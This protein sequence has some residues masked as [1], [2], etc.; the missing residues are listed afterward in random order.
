[1]DLHEPFGIPKVYETT[2]D[3]HTYLSNKT[4]KKYNIKFKGF[5][6]Y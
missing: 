5:A 1:M 3:T 6:L 2:A 4:T